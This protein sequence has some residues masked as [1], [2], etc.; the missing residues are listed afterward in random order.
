MLL[1]LQ[2]QLLVSCSHFLK[3]ESGFEITSRHVIKV[4][5]QNLGFG[6]LGRSLWWGA[7]GN[8][9]TNVSDRHSRTPRSK[10]A[11]VTQRARDESRDGEGLV[12]V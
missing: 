10:N 2:L 12:G 1:Q 8:E 9:R 7:R 11:V 4:P 3:F 5:L 6:A